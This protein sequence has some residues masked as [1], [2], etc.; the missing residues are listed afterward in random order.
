MFTHFVGAS[1]ESADLAAMLRHIMGDL[2][3][4]FSLK[5]EI[6]S[7]PVELRN[8]FGNWLYMAAAVS[9]YVL[10]IDGLN[11]LEDLYGAAELLWL[12]SELPPNTS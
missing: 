11:N 3:Q 4:S 8:A 10:L 6:P 7:D 2:K 9:R 1:R 5:E 12:P